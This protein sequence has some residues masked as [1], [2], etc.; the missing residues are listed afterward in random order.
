MH[1]IIQNSEIAEENKSKLMNENKHID[2]Q[3]LT[4]D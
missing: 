4:P 2:L 3:F 1:V